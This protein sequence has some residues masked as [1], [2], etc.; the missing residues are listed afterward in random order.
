[1]LSPTMTHCENKKLPMVQ[2][3][4]CSPHKRKSTHNFGVLWFS[5]PDVGDTFLLDVYY[6]QQQGLYRLSCSN[7]ACCVWVSCVICLPFNTKTA[8]MSVFCVVSYHCL[9]ERIHMP[10]A[11][12]KESW[13]GHT[14]PVIFATRPFSQPGFT[15]RFGQ[16]PLS[17][18]SQAASAIGYC[19]S[20]SLSSRQSKKLHSGWADHPPGMVQCLHP[21]NPPITNCMSFVGCHLFCVLLMFFSI[22]P[23]FPTLTPL[24]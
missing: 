4:F 14:E 24:S 18:A 21:E 6:Q 20:S 12:R 13:I 5:D 1:M 22:L 2:W 7:I 9:K 11:W 8:I 3:P 23:G 17:F 15:K 19:W 16:V 10:Q